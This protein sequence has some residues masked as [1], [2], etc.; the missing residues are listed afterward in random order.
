MSYDPLSEEELRR[1]RRVYLFD[2][3]Y[4]DNKICEIE[5]TL[6]EIVELE[7]AILIV[8]ADHGD[9]L[10]ERGLWYKMNFLDFFGARTSFHVRIGDSDG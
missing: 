5:Q 4:F 3:S 6:D 2:V 1:A 8:T 9:M 7:N 10:G